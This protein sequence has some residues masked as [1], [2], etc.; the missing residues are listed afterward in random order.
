MIILKIKTTSGKKSGN[1][2]YILLSIVLE[3][4]PDLKLPQGSGGIDYNSTL[5]S[6]KIIQLNSY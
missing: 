5:G 6:E 4:A 2:K 3:L 1:V